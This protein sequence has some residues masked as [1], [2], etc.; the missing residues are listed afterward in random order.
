MTLR[1]P[2][3][4]PR[5]LDRYDTQFYEQHGARSLGRS[6]RFTHTSCCDTRV[7]CST[8]S[9]TS[10]TTARS[11]KTAREVAERAALGAPGS[12]RWDI[13]PSALLAQTFVGAVSASQSHAG[14]SG[15]QKAAGAC[16]DV[17][18][19]RLRAGGLER[20]L[21]AEDVRAGGQDFADD[22]GLAGFLPARLTSSL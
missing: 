15:G 6:R 8:P 19:A 2:P 22:R 10:S 5:H 3:G 11:K 9:S 7:G 16:R 1:P 12:E 17:G 4:S 20:L 18:A 13:S 21:A 14:P